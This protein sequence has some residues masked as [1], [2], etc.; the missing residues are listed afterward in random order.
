[1]IRAL[2]N[3]INKEAHYIE[4]KHFQFLKAI[5]TELYCAKKFR[6]F[7]KTNKMTF[8][9]FILHIYFLR[10]IVSSKWMRL[11]QFIMYDCNSDSD[12]LICIKQLCDTYMNIKKNIIDLNYISDRTIYLIYNVLNVYKNINPIKSEIANY[13]LLHTDIDMGYLS[14]YVQFFIHGVNL[15]S[16]IN[17]ERLTSKFDLFESSLKNLQ[18]ENKNNKEC[19]KTILY[20]ETKCVSDFGSVLIVLIIN[21]L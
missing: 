10:Y 4:N 9:S 18:E 2:Y 16:I 12:F 5:K 20:N 6:A 15:Q 19:I 11:L 21:Y 7:L 13:I 17:E 14:Y 3:D 1:M 8:D